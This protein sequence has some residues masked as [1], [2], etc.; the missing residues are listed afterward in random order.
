MNNSYYYHIS[1]CF[2]DII[3]DMVHKIVNKIRNNVTINTN[4]LLQFM[5]INLPN[6]LL[7]QMAKYTIDR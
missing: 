6:N 5:F 3:K 7:S 2:A 1:Y 4:S